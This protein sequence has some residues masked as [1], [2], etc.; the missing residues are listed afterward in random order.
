M[1]CRLENWRK[2]RAPDLQCIAEGEPSP[3]RQLCLAGPPFLKMVIAAK[4]SDR[5]AA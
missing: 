2:Q 1:H 5:W 4:E 3:D